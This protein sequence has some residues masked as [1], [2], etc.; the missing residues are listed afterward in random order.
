MVRGASQA[1]GVDG[2]DAAMLVHVVCH[3][4]SGLW[5]EGSDDIGWRDEFVRRDVHHMQRVS[6]VHP[7]SGKLLHE[8]IAQG[9]SP[10]GE[11][12]LRVGQDLRT[13]QIGEVSLR[14]QVAGIKESA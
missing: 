12:M 9:I 13:I 1:L 11:L 8:G 5:T 3:R 2:I 10:A 4:I 7:I 6:V 14:A